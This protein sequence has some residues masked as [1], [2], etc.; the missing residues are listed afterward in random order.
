MQSDNLELGMGTRCEPD[1]GY[2]SQQNPNLWHP[3]QIKNLFFF[4]THEVIFSQLKKLKRYK[5]YA[6]LHR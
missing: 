2:L 6:Y 3:V 4:I 1:F 5:K